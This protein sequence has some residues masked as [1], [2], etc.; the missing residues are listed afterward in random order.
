[1]PEV[2]LPAD[3]RPP[4]VLACLAELLSGQ[5]LSDGGNFFSLSA[6][7]AAAILRRFQE[8]YPADFRL[9]GKEA[10]SAWHEQQ[11]LRCEQ[12]WN[13]LGAIFHLEILARSGPADATRQQRL[14]YARDQWQRLSKGAAAGIEPHRVIPSRPWNADER[15]VDLTDSYTV[16]IKDSLSV[17]NRRETLANLPCGVQ[18]LGGVEFDIRGVVFPPRTEEVINASFSARPRSVPLG[19]KAV[20]VH[21]LHGR[22]A[23]SADDSFSGGYQVRYA[24]GSVLSYPLGA[25]DLLPMHESGLWESLYPVATHR[26]AAF[27][28]CV[29]AW[30]GVNPEAEKRNDLVRLTRLTW[31]NPHPDKMI[32]RIGFSSSEA[33]NFFVVAI[34]V[35]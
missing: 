6:A 28:E 8:E 30:V 14:K 35:E 32:E 24:D 12:D 11:A 22:L 21:F 27:E 29:L 18:R 16:S 31:R 33:R 20:R 9:A 5:R 1:M 4:D 34:T 26:S 10:S 7:E 23:G 2:P 19:R 13:W 17:D 15:L 3:G 25:G